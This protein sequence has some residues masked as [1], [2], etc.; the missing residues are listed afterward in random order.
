MGAIEFGSLWRFR[1]HIGILEKV[2]PF[3]VVLDRECVVFLD[4]IS[5]LLVFIFRFLCRNVFVS[6]PFRSVIW[7]NDIDGKYIFKAEIYV[8]KAFGTFKLPAKMYAIV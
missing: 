4:Y 8:C 5:S 1:V 3:D 6:L 2:F 7:Y